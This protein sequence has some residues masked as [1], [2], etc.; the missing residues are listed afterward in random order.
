MTHT[1]LY[2][3]PQ[4]SLEAATRREYMLGRSD[5]Q[6]NTGWKPVPRNTAPPT[7]GGANHASACRRRLNGLA[8]RKKEDEAVVGWL[9]K[10]FVGR[11]LGWIWGLEGALERVGL[12]GLGGDLGGVFCYH[13]VVKGRN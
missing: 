2:R 3:H 12:R 10:L 11:W 9:H 1:G 5:R 6:R 4:A 13:I 8:G 7:G